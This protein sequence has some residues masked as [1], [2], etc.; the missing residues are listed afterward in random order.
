MTNDARSKEESATAMLATALMSKRSDGHIVAPTATEATNLLGC[1]DSYNTGM[2]A[3][4]LLVPKS[5]IQELGLNEVLWGRAA[6]VH[7]T[8]GRA[9][10][11]VDYMTGIELIGRLEVVAGKK[12][13]DAQA[14]KQ[15]VDASRGD[16]EI[17]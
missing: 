7:T 13:K 8:D 17:A 5:K 11:D 3:F 12:W 4:N 15:R 10:Y 16:K 14:L 1:I 9:V 6:P 2:G